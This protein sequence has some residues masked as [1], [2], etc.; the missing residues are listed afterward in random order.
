MM[1]DLAERKQTSLKY[2]ANGRS[3]TEGRTNEYN[4]EYAVH[5]SLSIHLSL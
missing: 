4:T 2:I 3:T 5:E 1:H